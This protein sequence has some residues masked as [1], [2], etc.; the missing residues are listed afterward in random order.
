MAARRSR[1][2]VLRARD[3]RAKKLVLAL[4]PLLALLAALQ[5]PKLLH[6]GGNAS[7]AAPPV[8]VASAPTGAA[9]SVAAAPTLAGSP[10]AAPAAQVAAAALAV[11]SAPPPA[12]DGQLVAFNLFASKDPFEQQMTEQGDGAGEGSSTSTTP[13]DGRKPAG[14][15][16]AGGAAPAH[17]SASAAQ[18]VSVALVSVNGVVQQV[19]A[20]GDFPAAAPV[21]HLVSFTAS[22]ARISVV[23]GAYEDGSP[24]LT[25]PKGKLV[26]LMNTADGTRYVLVFRRAAKAAPGAAQPAAGSV[27]AAAPAQTVPTSVA[28]VPGADEPTPT[29]TVTTP[30]PTTAG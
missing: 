22:A 12:R 15:T 19:Q 30:A 6:R 8:V 16:G 5:G 29:T 7:T 13:A 17:P 9:P 11:S 23:D 20:G 25:L 10:A 26:T 28:D 1:A 21:F 2:D 14:E 24:T 4:I 18:G 27:P 3:A